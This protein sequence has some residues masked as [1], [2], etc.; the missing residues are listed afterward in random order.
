MT[1]HVCQGCGGHGEICTACGENHKR[2]HAQY[3]ACRARKTRPC[4]GFTPPAEATGLAVPPTTAHFETF[5]ECDVCRVRKP[6]RFFG[7]TRYTSESH[8]WQHLRRAEQDYVEASLQVC[9]DCAKAHEKIRAM[10][11]E[12]LM[13]ERGGLRMG[14]WAR[15]N[16][17]AG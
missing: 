8:G 11:L 6:G 15:V 12:Y 9:P 10:T 2:R 16:P 14:E 1:T 4:P 7:D 3:R 5:T 13:T 17:A